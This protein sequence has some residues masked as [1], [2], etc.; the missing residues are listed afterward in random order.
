MFETEHAEA[1]AYLE[2]EQKHLDIP[3]LERELAGLLEGMTGE[4]T[5][6]MWTFEDG[7]LYLHMRT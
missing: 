6:E 5:R 1:K 7:I 4:Y 2:R 3:A